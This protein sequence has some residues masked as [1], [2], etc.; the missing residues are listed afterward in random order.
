MRSRFSKAYAGVIKNVGM[1]YNIQD[2]FDMEGYFSFKV[3]PLEAN[4][5]L[6]GERKQGELDEVVANRHDWLNQCFF[7]VGKWEPHMV[8]ADKVTWLHI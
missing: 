4:I 7:E 3:T 1:P 5:C 2:I 6:L 8:D